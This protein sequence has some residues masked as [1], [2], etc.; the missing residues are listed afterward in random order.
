MNH[1][2]LSRQFLSTADNESCFLATYMLIICTQTTFCVA[3]GQKAYQ[4]VP[5]KN[6][7]GNGN[8]S[9]SLFADWYQSVRIRLPSSRRNSTFPLEVFTRMSWPL[10]SASTALLEQIQRT[11]F[12]SLRRS[13]T[14]PLPVV[15]SILLPSALKSAETALVP[16]QLIVRMRFPLLSRSSTMPCLT[17]TIFIP[18]PFPK[19]YSSFNVKFPNSF[20]IENSRN[21]SKLT[22]RTT[23]W[24]CPFATMLHHCWTARH[25]S[26]ECFAHTPEYRHSCSDHTARQRTVRQP[27]GSDWNL[28]YLTSSIRTSFS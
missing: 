28:H 20:L 17:N 11:R 26:G 5:E 25:I 24:I 7:Q 19:D 12:P 27:A 2:V 21:L 10:Q 16:E 23:E 22:L 14:S 18:I 3:S 6:K 4:F 1:S 9:V 15:I 8:F 13:S